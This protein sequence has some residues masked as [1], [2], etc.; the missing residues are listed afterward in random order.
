MKL[1][2]IIYAALLAAL[3]VPG[4]AL[5]ENKKPVIVNSVQGNMPRKYAVVYTTINKKPV[6]PAK[7]GEEGDLPEE[8]KPI[9]TRSVLG[10]INGDSG[11]T[12]EY[13]N[14]PLT[15]PIKEIEYKSDLPEQIA[16]V[17]GAVNPKAGLV[18]GALAVITNEAMRIAG[19]KMTEIYGNDP[20]EL[21]LIEILPSQYYKI[22]ESSGEISVTTPFYADC[23]KYNDLLA[24]YIPAAQK[25]NSVITQYN[26]AYETWSVR[27]ITRSDRTA[28]ENLKKMYA[29]TVEPVLKQ[30]LALELQLETYALHRIA[31]IPSLNKPGT[32]CSSIGYQGPYSLMVYF[33]VGGMLSN[34]FNVDLCGK[35]T[36][37]NQQ[38]IVDLIP[39][40]VD[41]KGNF[42]PG[43]VRLSA[44][45][46]KSATFPVSAGAQRVNYQ[47]TQSRLLNWFDEM[48]VKEKATNI[49][50]YLISF[51]VNDLRA[52]YQKLVD[53]KK[54]KQAKK[55]MKI[56]DAA[57][58]SYKA[59]TPDALEKAQKEEDE[60]EEE[61]PPKTETPKVDTPKPAETPKTETP[62]IEA[63]KTETPLMIEAPKGKTYYEILQ[64]APTATEAEITKAYRTL[65][66][67]LHPDRNQSATAV[68]EFQEIDDAYKI[69]KDLDKRKQYDAVLIGR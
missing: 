7:A 50:S 63:P 40:R 67:K 65:S 44:T 24:A 32:S 56:L 68:K 20:L 34:I 16:K 62:L 39:N 42:Q 46:D 10:Y 26:K 6:P 69:L 66:L 61:T 19:E 52:S 27:D 31:I 14:K 5:S 3:M 29:D 4:I 2:K 9:I 64:V 49:N 41:E 53:K 59:G 11:K 48:I 17:A 58:E 54:S 60:D 36:M 28:I 1:I 43:G 37:Q 35:S 51:D 15:I 8:Q 12:S 30:K 33:Y 38:I 13:V 18:G 57:I 23:N 25:W 47:S 22:D 21:N 55:N 45:D